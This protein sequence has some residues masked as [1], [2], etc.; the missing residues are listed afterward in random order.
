MAPYAPP[1][2]GLPRVDRRPRPRRDL[3]AHRATLRPPCPTDRRSAMRRGTR[4]RMLWME[5]ISPSS[6][7]TQRYF[8]RAVRLRSGRTAATR[9]RLT[10]EETVHVDEIDAGERGERALGRRGAPTSRRSARMPTATPRPASVRS[11]RGRADCRSCGRSHG[12][13]CWNPG[14]TSRARA[15]GADRDRA[16]RGL[17]L[18]VRHAPVLAVDRSACTGSASENESLDCH[19]CRAPQ[20]R[21]T[22]SPSSPPSGSIGNAMPSFS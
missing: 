17:G 22:R 19:A 10:I 6:L 3:A 13:A 8:F 11:A 14:S 5:N 21:D 2:L 15:V 20:W 4:R 12:A 7:L 16:L 9:T 18:E 1:P